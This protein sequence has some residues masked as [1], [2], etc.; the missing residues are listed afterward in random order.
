MS[1]SNTT[2]YFYWD[3]SKLSEHL[4]LQDTFCDNCKYRPTR[5]TCDCDRF[6]Y[7]SGVC[8]AFEWVNQTAFKNYKEQVLKNWA[9][10]FY[11]KKGLTSDQIHKIPKQKL[12]SVLTRAQINYFEKRIAEDKAQS[13]EVNRQKSLGCKC[14]EDYKKLMTAGQPIT[15]KDRPERK[16]TPLEEQKIHYFYVHTIDGLPKIYR[17]R[18]N[19]KGYKS[20]VVQMRK[21]ILKNNMTLIKEEIK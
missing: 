8:I 6:I 1:A 15:A 4:L 18:T 5:G 7:S 13:E 10:T 21:F 14:S 9:T 16:I 11:F 17:K 3:S 20:D 19:S 12:L 2:E